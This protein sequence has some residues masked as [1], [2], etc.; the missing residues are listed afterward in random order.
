MYKANVGNIP[1]RLNV[2]SRVKSREPRQFKLSL[3]LS[4]RFEKSIETG[5]TLDTDSLRLFG[6]NR[7]YTAEICRVGQRYDELLGF[8]TLF[9]ANRC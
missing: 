4:L 1:A 8:T 9:V 6:R 2:L 7:G 5:I 3:K